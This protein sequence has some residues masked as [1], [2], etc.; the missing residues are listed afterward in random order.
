MSVRWACPNV[1]VWS[2]TRQNGSW[3]KRATS[4][5]VVKAHLF[6]F[7]GLSWGIWVPCQT[8]NFPFR[9]TIHWPPEALKPSSPQ[10]EFHPPNLEEVDELEDLQDRNALHHSKGSTMGQWMKQWIIMMLN[11]AKLLELDTALSLRV[12]LCDIYFIWSFERFWK[13]I[14]IRDRPRQFLTH[15]LGLAWTVP[16]WALET[17]QRWNS[18]KVGF[19]VEK[20]L[21]LLQVHDWTSKEIRCLSVWVAYTLANL[22]GLGLGDQSSIFPD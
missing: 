14:L 15:F 22:F 16:L 21:E 3:H 10:A 1:I 20:L 19:H 9:T 7:F 11:I 8:S 4:A 17:E 6:R 5:A 2:W 13:S 18:P 12:Q